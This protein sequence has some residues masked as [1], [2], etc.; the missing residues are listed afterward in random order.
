MEGTEGKVGLGTSQ[1]CRAHLPGVTRCRLRGHT[2][3]GWTLLH[4]SLAV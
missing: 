2:D 4:C 3:L 1:G